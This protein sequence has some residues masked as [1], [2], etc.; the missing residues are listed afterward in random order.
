M[1]AYTPIFPLLS[2]VKSGFCPY[3]IISLGRGHIF[4]SSIFPDFY[5][6]DDPRLRVQ[7]YRAIDPTH[8]TRMAA[9]RA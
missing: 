3:G 7:H 9:S 5:C 4:L 2:L 6:L 1:L 8:T